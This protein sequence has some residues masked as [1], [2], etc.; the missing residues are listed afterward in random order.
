MCTFNESYSGSSVYPIS[1]SVIVPMTS[2]VAAEVATLIKGDDCGVDC[3]VKSKLLDGN[4]SISARI[5]DVHLEKINLYLPYA[6]K[7]TIIL[8]RKDEKTELK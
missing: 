8:K 2:V 5:W 6:L 4:E 3:P 1:A 7:A